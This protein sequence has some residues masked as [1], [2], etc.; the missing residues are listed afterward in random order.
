MAAKAKGVTGRV[1]FPVKLQFLF[2]KARYKVAHG[3][4]GSGKSWSIARALLILGARDGASLMELIPDAAM[5]LQAESILAQMG[6]LPGNLLGVS[7]TGQGADETA[8]ANMATLLGGVQA[9]LAFRAASEPQW[10]M[11]AQTMRIQTEGKQVRVG[12]S[13]D[14][15]L[16]YSLLSTMLSELGRKGVL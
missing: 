14:Q 4:R 7:L 2:K 5:L 12:F 15:P 8:A 10:A 9:M 6:R 11:I 13:V 1:E 3:G 16:V